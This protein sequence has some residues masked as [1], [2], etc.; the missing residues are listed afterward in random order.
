MQLF[1]FFEGFAL[2]EEQESQRSDGKQSILQHYL[3]FSTCFSNKAKGWGKKE[4]M[5]ESSRCYICMHHHCRD[6][7]LVVNHR[8]WGHRN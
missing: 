8:C 2:K 6:E 5:E 1:K 3:C 4:H 7:M